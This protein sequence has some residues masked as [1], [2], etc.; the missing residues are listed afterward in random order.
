MQPEN[1]PRIEYKYNKKQI[2]KNMTFYMFLALAAAASVF[3]PNH[4]MNGFL[5]PIITLPAAVYFSYLACHLLLK[6]FSKT[7]ALILSTTGINQPDFSFETVPWTRIQNIARIEDKKVDKIVISLDPD[8]ARTLPLRGWA[9]YVPSYFR[10]STP[11]ITI[12]L[13]A[14]EGEPDQIF[15]HC[16]EFWEQARAQQ[17]VEKSIESLLYNFNANQASSPIIDRKGQ[18]IFTYGL[19]A[20]LIA[21]YMAE[22][23]FGVNA[24]KS[25]SLSPQTLAELGGIYY[26]GIFAAGQWWRLFTA[27]FMHANISH[28]TGNCIALLMAGFAL[29]RLLGWRWFAAIFSACALGC[30]LVSV[31][32]NPHNLVS[33]GA[34]GGIVG[35][36]M[37]V[38]IISFR[39]PSGSVPTTMR[40]GAL[41]ILVPALWPSLSRSHGSLEIDYAGHIGG[42]I[43]G[44]VLTTA[45]LALCW[46]R[47][48]KRPRFGLYATLFSGFFAAVAVGSLWPIAHFKSG[49]TSNPFADYFAGNYPLAADHFAQLTKYGVNPPEYIILW[50]FIAQQRSNDPKAFSDLAAEEGWIDKNKWPSPVFRL[51]RGESSVDAV[52]AKAV[53]NNQLCEAEFYIGEWYDLSHDT[54]TAIDW[55]HAAIALCPTDFIEYDGAKAELKRIVN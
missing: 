38:F 49:M 22:L 30:S 45:L 41:R 50:R 20:I 23:H 39:F 9:S 3:L 32:F 47:E 12:L 28:I 35:L 37:A 33:V 7:S 51:F 17:S 25:D 4:K 19:I 55:F 27:P 34:S 31:L 42:A 26:R 8:F 18:P 52:T 54:D 5:N 43:T 46:P 2:L 29:E 53:D 1:M 13:K 24:Q 40:Y 15:K 11:K 44:A 21:A 6:I 14:L 16:S 10:E 48:S 36:I